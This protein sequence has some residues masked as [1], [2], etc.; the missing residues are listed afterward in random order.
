LFKEFV[1]VSTE[2]QPAERRY[3]K[4]SFASARFAQLGWRRFESAIEAAG[5]V[6]THEIVAYLL[7]KG[8]RYNINLACML[9][10]L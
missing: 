5:H 8:A 3:W 4:R 10:Y 6:G 9:G 7:A 2:V 1:S